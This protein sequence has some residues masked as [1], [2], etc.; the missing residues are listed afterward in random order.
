MN[1]AEDDDD[2]VSSLS[3][4][5][6]VQADDGVGLGVLRVIRDSRNLVSSGRSSARLNLV[7]SL[8]DPSRA[9]SDQLPVVICP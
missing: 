4:N 5:F 2:V 3:H 7:S 9:Q 1:L 6:P 8:A